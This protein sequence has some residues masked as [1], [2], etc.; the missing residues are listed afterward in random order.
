MSWLS[1]VIYRDVGEKAGRKT[2]RS[3]G[4]SLC[5]PKSSEDLAFAES[6]FRLVQVLGDAIGGSCELV[7]ITMFLVESHFE[8]LPVTY[9]KNLAVGYAGPSVLCLRG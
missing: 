1:N 9:L 5:T 6:V 3:R 8:R 4:V 2:R 7:A